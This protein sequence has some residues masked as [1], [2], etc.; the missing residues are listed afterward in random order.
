MAEGEMLWYAL[1]I[2]VALE[3]PQDRLVVVYHCERFTAARKGP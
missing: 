3:H 1:D 2:F